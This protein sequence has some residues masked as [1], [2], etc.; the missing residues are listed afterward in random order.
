MRGDIM[1]F[2][3]IKYLQMD[4][5]NREQVQDYVKA[6]FEENPLVD[7]KIGIGDFEILR[8]QES[9]L[10]TNGVR[11]SIIERGMGWDIDV[12][13]GSGRILGIHDGCRFY[14]GIYDREYTAMLYTKDATLAF[15]ISRYK[16]EINLAF[17]NTEILEEG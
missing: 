14:F 9:A 11:P 8:F 17:D 13:T 12:H 6:F 7:Y 15:F 5:G 2:I 16:G 4:R 10:S 1:D 3:V